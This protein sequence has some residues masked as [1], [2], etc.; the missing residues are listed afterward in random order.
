[1]ITASVLL[2]LAGAVIFLIGYVGYRN[3]FRKLLEE[4]VQGPHPWVIAGVTF[5]MLAG[6]LLLL[7]TVVA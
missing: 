5:A 7:Y 2:V 3:T 6:V 4:D 1:M